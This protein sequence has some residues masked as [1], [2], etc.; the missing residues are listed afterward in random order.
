MTLDTKHGT[1]TVQDLVDLF[2]QGRLNL[3]P[4]FQRKSVW[5]VSDR[6]LL[7]SS[8][9]DNIPLPSVY[10]YRQVGPGGRPV[11]DVIDGKQRIESMLAYMGLGP[12]HDRRNPLL[13]KRAFNEVDEV[14]WWAW[15]ELDN[16][17]KHTYLSTQVPTI[18]VDGDLAEIIELFVRINATGKKLTPQE[19][20]HAH[21]FT[22]PVLRDA[23][24]LADA[25][26]PTLLKAN[27]LSRSQIQ[28]MKHVELVTELMLAVHAGMPLNKK[29]KIDEV[30]K[31]DG[32]SAKEV[33][34]AAAALRSALTL[35]MAILP[36]LHTTRFHRLADFYTLVL[37]LHRLRDEGLGVT[38]HQSARNKFAGSLL[39]EFGR[40]VD[41]A[42]DR[43]SA[44]KPT[45][46][47]EEPYREYLMTVKEGTDSKPQRDKREKALRV[48]L[49]GVFEPLDTTRAFNDT[50]RRILWH[51]SDKKTCNLCKKP[52]A[53]WEDLAIDHVQAYI[54]GGSTKLSNGALAHKKCNSSAGA[55]RGR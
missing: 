14:E 4:A 47:S 2:K 52:I 17:T 45:S 53:K 15:K 43:I 9:F 31:G 13:V 42:N 1:K 3:S 7:V 21:Y 22:S 23:Q 19:K 24:R 6:R 48:V 12:V 32:L 41:A 46:T 20:R 35:A 25:L 40:S 29:R 8:L 36:D 54:K 30:I 18:E 33:K 50:Q 39:R 28:R 16:A 44:G 5:T 51:A 27:V 26:A 34:D 10:L 49:A 11:Y 37:L 55:K 38:A